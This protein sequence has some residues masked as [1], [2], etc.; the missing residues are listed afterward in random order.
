MNEFT[1]LDFALIALLSFIAS[2]VT[3]AIGFGLNIMLVSFLQ[4]F[5][6]PV[7]IVGLGI[8]L[9]TFSAAMR[10]VETRKINTSGTSW[11]MIVPGVLA[12]PLGLAI[13]YFSD[14]FFLKRLF[15]MI[16]LAGAVLLISTSKAKQQKLPKSKLAQA[17]QIALGA[18]GGLMGGSSSMSGP[19]IVFCSLIQHWEKMSAH[20]VFAR[21]FLATSITAG[22]GLYTIGLCDGRTMVI[23]LYLTPI[24]WT[25]F[26]AGIWVR[27]RIS[28]QRFRMYTTIC[29]ILLAIAGFVNTFFVSI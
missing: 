25:G 23:G 11:R 29:L 14:A 9:G 17:K 1:N 2:T 21:Y 18:V 7:Q 4:F 16:I 15:S 5:M 12:I 22:I 10:T 28:Q 6:P 20:A 13:L 3:T 19:A 27:N 26:I 8:V 24:V